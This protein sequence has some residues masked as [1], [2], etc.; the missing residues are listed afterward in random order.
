MKTVK[1]IKIKSE[2]SA[3][4]MNDKRVPSIVSSY[5]GNCTGVSLLSIIA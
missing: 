4:V 2:K 5:Q 3:K 1:E